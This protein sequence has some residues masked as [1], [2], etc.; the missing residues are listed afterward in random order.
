MGDHPNAT[1]RSRRIGDE[2]GI[3]RGK[4]I[5]SSSLSRLIASPG[6]R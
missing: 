4:E 3:E 2:F 6:E 5:A 1:C